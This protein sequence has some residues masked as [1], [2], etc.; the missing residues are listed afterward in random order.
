MPPG[1]AADTT[2][3]R[4][5]TGSVLAPSS[6]TNDQRQAP[7][8]IAPWHRTWNRAEGTLHDACLATGYKS[9]KGLEAH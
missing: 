8:I 5:A 4:S 7:P 1:K 9:G 2:P 3:E 6:V